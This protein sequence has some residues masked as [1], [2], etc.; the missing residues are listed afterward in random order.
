MES[1]NFLESFVVTAQTGSFSAA[2]RRL[3]LTPAGVS[4]NVARLEQQLGLR[5][6]HRSTRSLTLTDSGES[7]YQEVHTPFD[8]LRDAVSHAAEQNG[9]PSGTLKISV[10]VGF[11]REYLVPILGDFL[12]RYPA[13]VPDVHFDNRPVDLIGE[14]YD[15]AIGGGIELNEGVVARELAPAHVIVVASP[16]YMAD[17]PM[18]AHP[19]E[20]EAFDGIARRSV[21]SG[22]VFAWKLQNAVGEQCVVRH[23]TRMIFDDPE[24]MAAAAMQGLGIALIPMPHA[25][26][27]L[28]QGSL[29]RL[30][31]GWFALLG[32]ITLYYPSKKLL[33]PKTRVFVDYVVDAFR[34]GRINARLDSR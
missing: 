32:A 5:L 10:G 29:M 1:F 8:A 20:L 34:A 31:P 18:P 30:L 6:F 13:I 4:K 9:A 3:G 17:K 22:R 2:A 23:R 7:F 12:A 25:A 28:Q 26:R 16:A 14:G 19:S 24:A 11:G 15:A 21:S 27:W 33:P